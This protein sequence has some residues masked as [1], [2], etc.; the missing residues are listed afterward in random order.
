MTLLTPHKGY[1]DFYYG[2]MRGKTPKMSFYR[3]IRT[4]TVRSGGTNVVPA[5]TDT[6]SITVPFGTRPVP[7]TKVRTFSEGNC[8]NSFGIAFKKHV[9]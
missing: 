6:K 3:G 7:F 9:F 8:D 2:K 4:H 1:I 5:S